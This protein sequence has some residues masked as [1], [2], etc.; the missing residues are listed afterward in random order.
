MPGSFSR[1]ILVLVAFSL[2][3]ISWGQGKG[4]EKAGKDLMA[5]DR[6]FAAATSKRGLDGWME[7]MT[8]DAVRLHKLGGKAI[9]GH[10]AIRKA[11]GPLFADPTKKLVWEP[12]EAGA[13]QDGRHGF[14]TGKY[15][16]LKREADGS[17][18]VLSKGS[19]LTWWRKEK[20][21]W[22]VILDTGTPD[23]P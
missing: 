18:K 3:G 21:G 12:T 8:E 11:D 17:D 10:A 14:T 16:V 15:R 20:N 19:Y 1:L 4:E 13:F 7:F 5:A 23:R 22:R 9:R 6:A 2:L